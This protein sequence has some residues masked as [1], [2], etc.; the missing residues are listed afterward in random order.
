VTTN[1]RAEP[2]LVFVEGKIPVLCL[3]QY[4]FRTRN[5][6]FGIDQFC[7]R[8]VF[9]T[10]FALVAIGMRIVAVRAF[11]SDVAVG[12]E[13]FRFFVVVLFRFAFQKLTL[14][15]ELSEEIGSHFLMGVAGGARID[16]E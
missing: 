3:A 1:P 16:V 8:K 4:G 15:I 2:L 7:G 6:G 5:F 10:L 11:A 13:G 12:E 14:I 9:T